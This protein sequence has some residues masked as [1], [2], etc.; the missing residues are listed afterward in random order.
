METI[1]DLPVT[2]R[3]FFI[4]FLLVLLVVLMFWLT[5]GRRRFDGAGL[6]TARGSQLRLAVIDAAAV[7]RRR[8]LVLIRRDDI[9]HLLMTGGPEDIVVEQNIVCPTPVPSPH[10][11]HMPRRPMLRDIMRAADAAMASEPEFG[12]SWAKPPSNSAPPL[13]LTRA[14]E[15]ASKML[16]STEPPRAAPPET[17]SAVVTSTLN[18]LERDLAS[19]LGYPTEE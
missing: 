12:P 3:F 2:G 17:K 1:F 14:P 15:P 6:G 8:R 7:D 13:R 10:E 18:N 9:E 16:P 5:R 11:A 19:L 4:A